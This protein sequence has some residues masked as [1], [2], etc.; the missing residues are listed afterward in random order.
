M[1]I[2]FFIIQTH[3]RVFNNLGNVS[4]PGLGIYD[5]FVK[6]QLNIKLLMQ[7][8]FGNKYKVYTS[9]LRVLLIPINITSDTVSFG[10]FKN[11]WIKIKW[12]LDVIQVKIL[13][14]LTFTCA[15][16]NAKSTKQYMVTNIVK[17]SIGNS[18]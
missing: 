17:K 9:I 18:V 2:Y 5:R 8:T 6:R 7:K 15:I 13:F 3:T 16:N 10:L 14:L 11:M 12:C 1:F 4:I